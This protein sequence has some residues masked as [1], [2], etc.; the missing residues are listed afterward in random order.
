MAGKLNDLDIPRPPT[1]TTGPSTMSSRVTDLSDSSAPSDEPAREPNSTIAPRMETT[2]PRT[3]IVGEGIAISGDIK[4]CN[5]LVV[6]GSL[7][8]TL[9]DCGQLEIAAKSIFKG[10]ATIEHGEV[11]GRFEGELM[12]SKCLRIRST[13]HVSGTITY[14]QI[15]I[16]RGGKLSGTVRANE[17]GTGMPNLGIVCAGE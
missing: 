1:R 9:H 6:E 10:S 16:E 13:G 3:M 4:S 8:A 7:E 5:R 14:G 11:S 17:N 2:E 15:E 12:V